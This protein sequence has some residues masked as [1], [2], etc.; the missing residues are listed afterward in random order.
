MRFLYCLLLM[1]IPAAARQTDAPVVE[2]FIPAILDAQMDFSF[3]RA[4]PVVTA[5]YSEVG[6]DVEWRLS[7]P[8]IAGCSKKPL[9]RTIVVALN[10]N[11]P[12]DFHSGALAFSNPHAV[13]GACVTLFMDR[14]KR[15]VAGQPF[16]TSFLLGNVL[17]HEIGHVLQ[18]IARH[19]ETGV[20]KPRWSVTEIEEMPFRR[21]HFTP[22]DANLILDGFGQLPE[23]KPARA[24]DLE[25][26]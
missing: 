21:L 17:A 2:V 7:K 23:V 1:T 10:W 25:G 3:H 8:Q 12:A 9:H 4:W 6:L 13:E 26:Q 22:Y 5:A 14:L 18:G 19:S 11:T 16:T 24:S 20:L 15:L